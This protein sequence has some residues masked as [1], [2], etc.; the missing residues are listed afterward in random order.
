MT[1]LAKDVSSHP[2]DRELRHTL[3]DYGVSVSGIR[4]IEERHKSRINGLLDIVGTVMELDNIAKPTTE[5]LLPGEF[6]ALSSD[7]PFT[8]NLNPHKLTSSWIRTVVR[9]LLRESPQDSWLDDAWQKVA[10]DPTLGTLEKFAEGKFSRDPSLPDSFVLPNTKEWL[11]MYERV[12]EEGNPTKK[13]WIDANVW[14]GGVLCM[15]GP[16]NARRN[17]KGYDAGFELG[18]MK[19]YLHAQYEA[20]PPH[21][22]RPELRYQEAILAEELAVLWK[23]DTPADIAKKVNVPNSFLFDVNDPNVPFDDYK[24]KYS[25]QTDS[26]DKRWGV[27]GAHMAQ[28]A[29]DIFGSMANS[30]TASE[31][32]RG[33]A[34]CRQTDMKLRSLSILAT[35]TTNRQ[36]RERLAR[37]YAA[38]NDE[39]LTYLIDQM[40]TYTYRR[41]RPRKSILF[42]WHVVAAE[43][44]RL[45]DNGDMTQLVRL[46]LPR[47]DMVHVEAPPIH[48]PSGTKLS[49]SSDAITEDLK[50][51][52][53]K[54]LQAKFMPASGLAA[55]AQQHGSRKYLRDIDI[56]TVNEPHGQQDRLWN[57]LHGVSPGKKKKTSR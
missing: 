26:I 23:I 25:I 57:L 29:A 54:R 47:E 16:R 46:A 39:F 49:I 41:D 45:I 13:F 19:Y 44:Q 36:A 38:T 3:R 14:V 55:N 43:R 6:D 28:E 34:R 37:E 21:E 7:K 10:D 42:E 27:I 22:Q 24:R 17:E 40:D 8:N 1:E 32:A 12:C 53:H 50:G 9:D 20:L 51:K 33:E 56:V 2:Y 30:K 35:T 11:D 5:R 18:R 15:M 48:T 4:T 52:T 31:E